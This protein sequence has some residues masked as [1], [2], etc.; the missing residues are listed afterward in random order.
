MLLRTPRCRQSWRCRWP[1]TIDSNIC[2]QRQSQELR[3]V[4]WR[5]TFQ[6]QRSPAFSCKGCWM[7]SSTSSVKNITAFQSW[8][9]FQVRAIRDVSQRLV[10]NYLSH[11]QTTSQPP[12]STCRG[13]LRWSSSQLRYLQLFPCTPDC[14]KK[15]M[16]ALPRGGQRV[17]TVKVFIIS[18][19]LEGTT[20]RN[21]DGFLLL[22]PLFSTPADFPPEDCVTERQSSHGGL[23]CLAVT[24]YQTLL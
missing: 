1:V 11:Q 4:G 17:L 19:S 7:P 18:H 10:L 16:H 14:E 21:V 23:Y 6:K 9:F 8:R 5:E 2:P 15:N 3:R 20:F 12:L 22:T 24:T 13:N